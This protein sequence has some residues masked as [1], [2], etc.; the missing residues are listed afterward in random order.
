MT[1]GA[2]DRPLPDEVRWL[3]WGTRALDDVFRI[4]GTNWRFGLDP[5][6]GL[7]PGIGDASAAVLS[8]ALLGSAVR[9]GVPR[10][11]LLRMGLNVVADYLVGLVPGLGD[12]ADVFFK[13]NRRNLTLLRRH[14]TG[15]P[16]GAADYLI[17]GGAAAVVAGAILAGVAISIWLLAA[18]ARL[19]A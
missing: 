17:V 13:S 4:P 5:I 7:V 9:M 12:V 16:A 18:L 19:I 6:L 10:V 3:E 15:R 8:V 14:A 11:V 2:D 1:D